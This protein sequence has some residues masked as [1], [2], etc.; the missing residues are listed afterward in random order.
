MEISN[1]RC[2]GT[3]TFW[4]PEKKYGFAENWHSNYEHIFVHVANV[5][6]QIRLAQGDII[7]F[8]VAASPT[9]P[10][11]LTAKQVQLLRRAAQAP[12]TVVPVKDA[13]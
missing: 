2:T 7:S 13:Q 5:E 10:G 11:K 9:K 8:V 12:A 6:G 4:N 1:E 3:I